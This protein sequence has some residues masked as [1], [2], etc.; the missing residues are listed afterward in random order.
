MNKKTV[1]T[2]ALQAAKHVKTEQDLN[3]FS[4]I[5]KKITD[6]TAPSAEL[7]KH[8]GYNKHAVSAP[9]IA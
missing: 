6:E 5:L 8:P 4:R 7:D 3:D 2:L 9:P 1:G